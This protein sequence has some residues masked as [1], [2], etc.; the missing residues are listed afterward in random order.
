MTTEDLFGLAL[1]LAGV[2]AVATAF[3][4]IMFTLLGPIGFSG[5]LLWQIAL[6]ALGMYLLRGAPHVVR[7]A[8]P[9]HPAGFRIPGTEV[10]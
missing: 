2:I 7:F 4:A 5:S 9:K 10:R 3:Q 6:L 1:R 8:Y